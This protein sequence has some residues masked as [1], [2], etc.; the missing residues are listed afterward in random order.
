[1][2]CYG[3]LIENLRIDSIVPNYQLKPNIVNTNFLES[4]ETGQ[5]LLAFSGRAEKWTSVEH[6]DMIKSR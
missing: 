3:N 1:M 2:F 5:V 6:F 4:T